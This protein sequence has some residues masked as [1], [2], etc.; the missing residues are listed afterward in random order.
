MKPSLVSALWLLVAAGVALT[1]CSGDDVGTNAGPMDD[2]GASD[3]DARP[4]GDGGACVRAAAPA[5]CWTDPTT[6]LTWEVPQTPAACTWQ[7]ALD[8]CAALTACGHDDWRLPNIDELRTL[9]RGCAG[10]VTGGACAAHVGS[11]ASAY[12][13]ACWCTKLAGP[14]P[15]RCYWD[16][17]FGSECGTLAQWYWSSSDVTSWPS[18][19]A[20]SFFEGRVAPETKTHV[21]RL[22]CVRP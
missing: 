15:G 12:S 10:T 8:D 4:T 13:S 3:P 18:A 16:D 14:G 5:S 17:V 20:V 22:R 11:S 1:A 7:A 9:V 19:W 2:G 21:Q 6:Q